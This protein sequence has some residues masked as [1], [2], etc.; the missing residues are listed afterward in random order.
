[1]LL[2]FIQAVA[3]Q[4]GWGVAGDIPTRDNN[5]GDIE[6]GALA[7]RDGAI[8][9][10]ARNPRFAR[11]ATAEAGFAA[12]RD[13]LNHG[14]GD[15]GKPLYL[16]KTVHDALNT[17]APPVENDTS[18]YEANVCEWS[19]MSPATVLTAENIG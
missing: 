1:M 15:D 7:E 2:T 12:L 11:F 6:M 9:V 13:L 3:R 10:D 18:A 5:P 14:R 17:Y 8:G 4:E 16:G 19:G